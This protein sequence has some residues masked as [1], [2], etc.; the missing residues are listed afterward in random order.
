MKNIIKLSILALVLNSCAQ[1]YFS[2]PMPQKG[3]TVKS[4]IEDLQGEYQDSLLDVVIMKDAI[5][6]SGDKFS[7]TSKTPAEN[8]VLVKYYKDFYFTCFADSSYFE[9]Y[10]AKFYDEN[11]LA[12]Y[13]LNADES[14]RSR[15]ARFTNVETLDS[16]SFV[17]SP[18]NKEFE[19]LIDYGMFEVISVLE[20]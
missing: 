16:L 14:S 13:M 12:L 6:V 11:K 10:M 19:K 9:V 17:L 18:T 7:L 4:F 5:I 3:T 20:K 1:I 8:E 15:M 2:E